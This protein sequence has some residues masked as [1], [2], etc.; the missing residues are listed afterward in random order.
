MNF[1]RHLKGAG[2]DHLIITGKADSPVALFITEEGRFLLDV[3]ELWGED[4]FDTTDLLKKDYGIRGG[5]VVAIGPAGENGVVFSLALVDKS[6]TLGRGGLGAVM[7]SKNLKAMVALGK[8]R[9]R[10]YDKDRLHRLHA[11]IRDRLKRFKNHRR[12][13]EMGILENWDNY[14]LQLSACKNFG[15]VFPAD[16]AHALYGPDVYRRFKVK[17]FGC[18]S[19]FTPDKEHIE[20]VEGPYKGF[21]TTTTSYFNS[22]LLGRLFDLNQPTDQTVSLRLMDRLDRLG[23]DMFSFGGMMDFLITAHE[24]RGLQETLFDRPLKRDMESLKQWAKAIAA[25]EGSGE[26]LAG[27]WKAVMDYV[28]EDYRREAPLIKGCEVIWDPRLVGLGTMEFEQMVSLKGPRSASGGSPTYIPGQPEENLPIFRQHLDRMGA[29][30]GA[31]NR[32]MDSP[33]GF[34]VGRMTRYS[35]DWYSLMSS[36]GICGRSFMNRFYNH[37]LCGDLLSAATGHSLDAGLL[38]GAARRIWD[39]LKQL[40]EAEGFGPED[41]RPPEIWFQPMK[42][43]KGEV[44][45]IRDYF[46]K[47]EL[48]R[49]DLKDLTE[50]YYDERGWSV[51][52]VEPALS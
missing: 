12:V 11:G 49:K 17:R 4:I 7:G 30:E 5:S 21:K 39:T 44:L 20:V 32:I 40:N 31:I 25:R 33:L 13:I 24:E 2:Y 37:T 9:P 35:Q 36:L 34:N 10:I 22:F 14:V 8:K 46:G 6:S 23:L 19:C 26:L 50:D 29:D 3:P 28:G 42:G 27:G 18:P 41:D 38:R 1:A 15:R 47:T 48:T 16:K 51:Q 45:V 43:P 52:K